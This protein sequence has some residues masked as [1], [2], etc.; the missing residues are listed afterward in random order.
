MKQYSCK[1]GGI[2]AKSNWVNI[3]SDIF[4]PFDYQASS[5]FADPQCIS[6][7]EIVKNAKK[8]TI[9]TK[10]QPELNFEQEPN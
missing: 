9:K 4:G 3:L 2:Q 6:K 10:T 7:F 8:L 5:V 1:D